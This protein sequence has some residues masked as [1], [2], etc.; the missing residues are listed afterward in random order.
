MSS[1]NQKVNSGGST[2]DSD[3]E[4]DFNQN[5]T[6]AKRDQSFNDVSS[7]KKSCRERPEFL[8]NQHN[9]NIRIHNQPGCTSD[10]K[11]AVCNVSTDDKDKIPEK[12]TVG[13]AGYDLFTAGDVVIQ[14]GEKV[15]IGTGISLNLPKST[16]GVI[17]PRSGFSAKTD[18][19]VLTGVIDEDYTGEIKIMVKNWGEKPVEIKESTRLAQILIIPI[20][21]V[22]LTR[23]DRKDRGFGSSGIRS[24]KHW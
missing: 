24:R 6:G 15:M 20:I 4:V 12:A 13:S 9:I 14:P 16:A 2:T 7:G 8:E 17:L 3:I 21:H 10:F 11:E 19:L 1:L 5:I 18:L 22:T 23:N